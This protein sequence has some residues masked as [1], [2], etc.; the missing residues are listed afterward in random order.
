MMVEISPEVLEAMK[1]GFKEV[2]ENAAQ[3][4]K[5]VEGITEAGLK[6]ADIIMKKVV[7]AT[8]QITK[9]LEEAKQVAQ[10]LFKDFDVSIVKKQLSEIASSVSTET[11]A[12]VAE[13]SKT[14]LTF[15]A[16]PLT[17]VFDG[18]SD[19]ETVVSSLTD[20]VSELSSIFA[21]LG[22]KDEFF[23]GLIADASKVIERSNKMRAGL[24]DL[25]A[26]TGQLD[27]YLFE[28]AG[29]SEKL[30]AKLEE[31]NQ[32][33]Y[34]VAGRV[35]LTTNQVA[36]YASQLGK[37]PNALNAVDEYGNSLNVSLGGTTQSISQLE[38]A[39]KVA[40][41]T[42]QDMRSVT[43]YMSQ[44]YRLFN[45]TTQQSLENFSKMSEQSQRLRLPFDIMSDFVNR[46]A[47]DFKYFK[48]NTDAL[49]NV[50]G[51]L[52]PALK[53][54]GLAPEAI[55]ELSSTMVSNINQMS[56]AQRS[57]LSMQ[58]GGAGGLRGGYEIELLK[59]QGKFDE[60]QKKT[61]QALRK[62]FGGNVVTLEEAARDEGAARQLAKQ[63]EL[64]TRG[65]TKVVDTEAQAYKLFEAMR[66]G[67]T[68]ETIS[69]EDALSDTI[70]KAN[71]K[72]SDQLDPLTDLV[73]SL[74]NITQR[75]AAS[76]EISAKGISLLAADKIREVSETYDESLRKNDLGFVADAIK[77]RDLNPFTDFVSNKGLLTFN[78]PSIPNQL[79]PREK[80][81]EK[82]SSLFG[83]YNL[84]NLKPE[85]NASEL[86]PE[87]LNPTVQINKVLGAQE[88]FMKEMPVQRSEADITI[89]IKD[90]N[91]K[92]I[93]QATV[94]MI[95]GKIQQAQQ[96]ELMHNNIGF[97]F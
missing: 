32:L 23:T 80:M 85:I 33:N 26:S 47:G 87:L 22:I 37:I 7:P 19:N 25:M 4:A 43:E 56:L 60:I 18:L 3:T 95:D 12:T 79:S 66:K 35:G 15:K 8:K 17:K 10:G 39:I 41:G 50:M 42:G 54:S 67:M 75:E 36:A 44:G 31:F 27:Q 38:A 96:G 84:P 73:T 64:V 89:H 40:A 82:I 28:V 46:N 90:Q 94:K 45:L 34:E 21:N 52:G 48:D 58:T 61:E 77:Q 70:T 62:Q 9:G 63:V 65:P 6:Q 68:S 11:L 30:N 81:T 1:A 16:L 20:S 86:E 88:S 53:K 2:Q 91:N 78:N 59:A 72:I 76:A 13:I 69:K 93:G 97:S 57:F 5:Q 92:D 14:M 71:D 74:V 51:R 55:K 24:Y 49:I 83:E 29:S